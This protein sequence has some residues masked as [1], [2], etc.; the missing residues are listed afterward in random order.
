MHRA[1]LLTAAFLGGFAGIRRIAAF[2]LP[3][4]LCLVGGLVLLLSAAVALVVG[5]LRRGPATTF[6]AV[7][8]ALEQLGRQL[9]AQQSAYGVWARGQETARERTARFGLDANPYGMESLADQLAS[10][11][12]AQASYT[13]WQEKFDEPMTLT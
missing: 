9:T 10:A 4:K 2:L 5:F 1:S 8:V 11:A 3:S 13:Q 7:H 6:E 12:K